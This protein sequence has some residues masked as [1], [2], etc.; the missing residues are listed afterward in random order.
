MTGH[1]FR[2]QRDITPPRDSMAFRY[3]LACHTN[4]RI[5]CDWSLLQ[6]AARYHSAQ[7]LD[8][9][10]VLVGLSHTQGLLV[11]GHC[12]TSLRDKTAKRLGD[13]GVVAGL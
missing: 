10:Q 2:L 6:T 5:T 12:C 1:C 8:G 9:V 3:W 11:T 13:A 7:G 4:T